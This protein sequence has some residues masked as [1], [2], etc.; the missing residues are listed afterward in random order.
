MLKDPKVPL[1]AKLF[2]VGTVRGD[3]D[4]KIV[5]ELKSSARDMGIQDRVEIL[6]NQP[7]DKLVEIFSKSKVAMHTMK[8]EHFG[9]AVVELMSSGIVTVA[10]DSAGP[11]RD[12]IGSSAT[13]VGY[14]AKSADQY[15]FI[16]KYALLN[17]DSE[18]LLSLRQYARAYVRDKFSIP[19][20]QKNFQ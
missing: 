15:S 4:Q 10:H 13:K 12:I 3:A 8:D 14:L 2:M 6:T 18:D 1:D 5:D 16:V 11:K 7:R 17:Y 19:A 9:I 20:F